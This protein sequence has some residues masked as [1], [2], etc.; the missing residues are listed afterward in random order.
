MTI[1]PSPIHL[2]SAIA[3]PAAATSCVPSQRA[4]ARTLHLVDIENLVA[5][6]ATGPN[7]RV[8][9][10]TYRRVI[11]VND[12]DQVRIACAT[13]AAATLAFAVPTGRQL[14][15]GGHGPDAADLALIDSVDIA[16][17]AARFQAVVIASSDH[18]FAPLAAALARAGLTVTIAHRAGNRCAAALALASHHQIALHYPLAIT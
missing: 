8:A 6:R 16:F 13:P 11:G 5:G 2:S 14:L 1:A 15:I 18:I 10:H 9:D 7:L 12:G 3:A 17:T 4:H